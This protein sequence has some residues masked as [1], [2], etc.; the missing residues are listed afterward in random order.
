[1]N[2]IAISQS[3]FRWIVAPAGLIIL[4]YYVLCFRPQQQELAGHIQ[5]RQELLKSAETVRSQ[6]AA[7]NQELEQARTREENESERL[8]RLEQTHSRLVMHTDTRTKRMLAS[9]TPVRGMRRLLEV[10]ARNNL[11]CVDNSPLPLDGNADEHGMRPLGPIAELVGNPSSDLNS[12]LAHRLTL[13]GRFA[14]MQAALREIAESH[15]ELI[16]LS[17][18]MELDDATSEQRRWILKVLL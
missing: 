14:D 4:G 15:H 16:P 13:A 17:L 6:R 11:T 1:M 18:S 10:L 5:A 2:R 12:R 7:A 8:L 9:S 3:A